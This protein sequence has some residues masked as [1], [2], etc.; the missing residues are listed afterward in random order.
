MAL[1]YSH[2]K[3]AGLFLMHACVHAL[4]LSRVRPSVT[5]WTA[6]LQA[7]HVGNCSSGC[8]S[9]MLLTEPVDEELPSVP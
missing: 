4:L 1:P 8:G 2:A 3:V 5:A 7:T 6:A 9:Q